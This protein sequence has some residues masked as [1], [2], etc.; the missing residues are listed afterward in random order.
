[1][2][3][4]RRDDDDERRPGVVNFHRGASALKLKGDGATGTI[5]LHQTISTLVSGSTI[6]AVGCWVRKNGTVTAGSNLQI[7][8][9]GT[10]FSGP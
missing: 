7:S 5:T 2:D 8:V 4:G 9:K 3:E 6:Y 1:V 10:G